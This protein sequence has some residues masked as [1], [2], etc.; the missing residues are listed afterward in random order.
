MSIV[1]NSVK[2]KDYCV[3]DA[4][5]LSSNDSTYEIVAMVFDMWNNPN[6]KPHDVFIIALEDVNINNISTFVW[7][8]DAQ[9][10]D[11]SDVEISNSNVEQRLKTQSDYKCS[12]NQ[13]L[14]V[15]ENSIEEY[16]AII[17]ASKN[18]IIKDDMASIS[19]I[20]NLFLWKR[21]LFNI[22]GVELKGDGSF[23]IQDETK[24]D[25]EINKLKLSGQYWIFPWCFDSK[26]LYYIDFDYRC[27]SC[28]KVNEEKRIKVRTINIIK[29]S[30]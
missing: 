22:L 23:Y 9:N 7:R 17:Y 20:P 16:E 8:T 3:S 24:Y 26:C 25:E 10:I 29:L 27:V 6:G 4:S 13:T 18:A 30:D 14:T 15:T 21:I 19:C 11:C 2:I 1:S 5:F 12:V 28:I